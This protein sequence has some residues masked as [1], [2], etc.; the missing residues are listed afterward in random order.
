M[1]GCTPPC[2]A[3]RRP[4]A[5]ETPTA[6][7]RVAQVQQL[8]RSKNKRSGE[9]KAYPGS[10]GPVLPLTHS[11]GSPAMVPRPPLAPRMSMAGSFRTGRPRGPSCSRPHLTELRVTG[12]DVQMHKARGRT[13]GPTSDGQQEGG[14]RV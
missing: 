7:D 5:Y 6:D 14:E 10:Q 4:L 2:S 11:L 12:P 3:L 8:E 13:H 9:S 1:A